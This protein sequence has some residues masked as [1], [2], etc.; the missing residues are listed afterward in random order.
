MS[1]AGGVFKVC[2][3]LESWD[4]GPNVCLRPSWDLPRLSAVNQPWA[5]GGHPAVSRAL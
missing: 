1:M 2:T 3:Y 5:R 4:L